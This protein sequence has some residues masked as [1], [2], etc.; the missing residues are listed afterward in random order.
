MSRSP[1]NLLSDVC[2]AVAGVI[3]LAAL[4]GWSGQI[5]WLGFAVANGPGIRPVTGACLLALSLA[6]ITARR[7]GIGMFVGAARWVLAAAL[8]ASGA[9]AAWLLTH[10]FLGIG[11]PQRASSPHTISAM[12]L[13]GLGVVLSVR[14]NRVRRQIAIVCALAGGIIT[15]LALLGYLTGMPLFFAV[16]GDPSAG[17]SVVTAFTLLV[18]SV[19]IMGLFPNHGFVALFMMQSEGGTLMRVLL[20]TAMLFPLAIGGLLNHGEHVGWFGHDVGL[21]LNLGVT[22]V[23]IIGLVLWIGLMFKRREAEQRAAAEERE[24]LLA[25]LRTS[26]DELSKLQNNLVTVC[27][28]TQRVLDE[29]KWVRFEEFLDKRLNI[30][31]T[32]GISEEAAKDELESLEDWMAQSADDPKP[33]RR[34]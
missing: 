22:S 26:L 33:G 2:G 19:G 8:L 32:H 12:V 34:G 28:W 13:L 4:L 3:G 17:I 11:G 30:S 14:A 21:A 24:V 9:L 29:G 16:P 10:L 27:A 23:T 20:P 6:L 31:I 7:L 18:L 25:S 15:W 5:T 1:A